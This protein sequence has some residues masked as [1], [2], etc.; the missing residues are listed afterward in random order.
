MKRSIWY[1]L[2]VFTIVLAACG[3]PTPATLPVSPAATTP[4]AEAVVTQPSAPNLAS[5]KAPPTDATIATPAMSV[6]SQGEDLQRLFTTHHAWQWVKSID[7]SGQEIA[8]AQPARYTLAFFVADGTVSVKAD[9]NTASG[10][11][12][13]DDRGRLSI[14][15]GPLTQ[16]ACSPGSL[17]EQFVKEL[18]AVQSYLFDGDQ[19]VLEWQMDDSVRMRFAKAESAPAPTARPRP[20]ATLTPQ[21]ATTLEF[22][23]DLV[24]CRAAPTAEKPGGIVLLFRFEPTGAPGP[25]RYFDRDENKEVTELYER[26]AAKGS[27]VVVSWAVQAGDGQLR[28]KKINYAASRFAEFG[29]K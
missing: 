13:A 4:A 3:S 14:T 15:L 11:F 10:K 21:P 2:L 20:M 25:Y 7:N 19:L 27:G 23:V 1:A 8:V 22:N 28:E 24:G 29:C 9:C 12:D 26:P 5:T 6:A 16:A 18:G 17:S